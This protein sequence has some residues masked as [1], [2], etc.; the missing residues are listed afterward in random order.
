M[1]KGAKPLKELCVHAP[2]LLPSLVTSPPSTALHR[3]HA[4]PQGQQ[5][6]CREE[7]SQGSG[8][9]LLPVVY[10]CPVFFLFWGATITE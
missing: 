8:W 5:Q 10:F 2:E 4:E 9:E 1:P 6:H 3:G 7:S